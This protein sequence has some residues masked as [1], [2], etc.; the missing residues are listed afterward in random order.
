MIER[1]NVT[2]CKKAVE[3]GAKI[4]ALTTAGLGAAV[5]SGATLGIAPA[6]VGISA[7]VLAAASQLASAKKEIVLSDPI[8]QETPE[9]SA[10]EKLENSKNTAPDSKDPFSR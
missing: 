1:K 3:A 7:A 6:V 2:R 8:T 10:V 4:T 5:L 9:Y